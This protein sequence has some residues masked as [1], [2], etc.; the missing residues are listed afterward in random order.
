MKTRGLWDTAKKDAALVYVS[1]EMAL[2]DGFAAL[3]TNAS[4][5]ARLT[6][7]IVDEAHCID[8]WGGDDFRPQYRELENLRTFTGQV[9][10]F[11]ACTAT[12]TT[13]TFDL[14]WK[15]LGFGYRP[16][17]GLDAGVARAN[18][19]YQVRA[20]ENHLHPLLDTQF[21]TDAIPL[22]RV[23]AQ[24]TA[25]SRSAPPRKDILPINY[26]DDLQ[27]YKFRVLFRDVTS[28][29]IR[30]FSC[31]NSMLHYQG[32]DISPV[33]LCPLSDPIASKKR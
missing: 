4:F 26:T 8:D 3:W 9:V 14:L 13:A 7:V 18:L 11:L 20:I 33:N 2:S 21:W 31:L 16:F 10:P 24:S 12:C 5:R 27:L 28:P 22:F 25:T 1:P 23:A 29:C 17:W 6:A 32:G 30:S 15:T 19:F